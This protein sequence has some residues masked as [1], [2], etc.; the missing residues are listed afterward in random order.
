MHPV[1]A[2][3]GHLVPAAIGLDKTLQPEPAHLARQQPQPRRVLLL[4]VI[5]KHLH[6]NADAHQGFVGRSVKHRCQ[7]R[8]IMS[9]AQFAHTIAHGTLPRQHHALGR[10]H[11][12]GVIG[13]HNF[14]AHALCRMLHGL[15]HRT[16]ITH[17]VIDHGHRGSPG[18]CAHKDPLVEG[19]TPAM[20]GSRSRANRKALAKAL[21][22]VSH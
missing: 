22:T 14:Q 6:A 20:R 16:Q 13:H 4:T 18:R 3:L 9:L 12:I 8:T 15:P 7:Q 17:T 2:H 11:H 19:I 21:N 1:P 10:V 5:Q